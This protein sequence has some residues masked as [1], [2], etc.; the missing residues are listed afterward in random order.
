MGAAWRRAGKDSGSGVAVTASSG[1]TTRVA[2]S[3]V[4]RGG[5]TIPSGPRKWR[6]QRLAAQDGQR[7]GEGALAGAE[8]VWTGF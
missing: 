2:V 1:D 5:V 4:A 7:P 8:P 3:L 6:H